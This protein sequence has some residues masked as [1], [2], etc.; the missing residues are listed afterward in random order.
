MILR[1]RFTQRLRDHHFDVAM[2]RYLQIE[3][4][5]LRRTM[6]KIDVTN[7]TKII[8]LPRQHGKSIWTLPKA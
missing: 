8:N 7:R 1:E 4:E 5:W 6:A 3:S 2:T